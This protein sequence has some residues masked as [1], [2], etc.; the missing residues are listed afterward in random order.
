MAMNTK[1]HG[2]RREGAGRPPLH[3]EPIKNRI[4]GLT[5][6]Q[7]AHLRE[8]GGGNRNEGVRRLL[9]WHRGLRGRP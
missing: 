7:D 3:D 4:V 5:D 9:D 6:E 8:I 2:G 1:R